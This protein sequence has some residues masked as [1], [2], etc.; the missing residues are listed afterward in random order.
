[1]VDLKRIFW[2]YYKYKRFK[3]GENKMKKTIK[4]VS[5][6]LSLSMALNTFTPGFN[7]IDYVINAEAIIKGDV[8][9]DGIVSGADAL[10]MT[11]YLLGQFEPD[12][13]AQINSDID[14]NGKINI[15]DMILIKE[16][17]ISGTVETTTTITEAVT[18]TEPEQP[19]T[20]A[21]TT[22]EPEQPTTEAVT[23]TAPE[24]TTTEAVTTTPKQTTTKATTTPKQ[25]TTKVTTTPKQTT[26]ATVTTTTEIPDMPDPSQNDT[27]REFVELINKK[28]AAVGRAPV[29]LDTK[30]SYIADVRAAEL[31]VAY[32]N[33]RPDGSEYTDLLRNYGITPYDSCQYIMKD[34]GSASGMM[35]AIASM[36]VYTRS[37]Y[38]KAGVGCYK[39]SKTYWVLFLIS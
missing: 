26:T 13:K 33:G 18:A 7:S 14:S 21:V 19:T 10:S 15:V 8:N 20:E 2:Y 39:G 25:T 37:I 38:Q 16:M 22:T 4:K 34:Y 30:L 5:V 32:Q 36:D 11:Q 24:Q 35:N 3:K 6:L 9:C 12:D 28:R 31:S 23:T 1:M 17:L 27:K 29:E